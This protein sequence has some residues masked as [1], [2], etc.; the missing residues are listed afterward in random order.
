MFKLVENN[1]YN[2]INLTVLAFFLSFCQLRLFNWSLYKSVVNQ[3][4][5]ITIYNPTGWREARYKVFEPKTFFSEDPREKDINAGRW[6]F[7][8][9]R[10]LYG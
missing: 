7:K 3:S 4:V 5:K 1:H 9:M 6:S 2:T 10:E 8:R